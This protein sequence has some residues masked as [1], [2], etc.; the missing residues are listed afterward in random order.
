ML[1][2]YLTRLVPWTL[3]VDMLYLRLAAPPVLLL[4]LTNL[5]ALSGFLFAVLLLRRELGGQLL[6]RAVNAAV[7]AY[8]TNLGTLYVILNGLVHAL[9]HNDV[10]F[11]LFASLATALLGFVMPYDLAKLLARGGG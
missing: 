11:A 1:R 10:I 3:L 9:L 6:E 4:L 5:T 7:A 8:F 2:S